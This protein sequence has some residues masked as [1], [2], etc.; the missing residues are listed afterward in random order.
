MPTFKFTRSSL[1]KGLAWFDKLSTNRC[2]GSVAVGVQRGKL[3]RLLSEENPPFAL[4]LS[5][6][7]TAWFDKLTT[8]GFVG[9]T[10]S[11]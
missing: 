6:G 8:S 3:A 11:P 5:K 10:S 7:L 9:S 1:P 4:S 2:F